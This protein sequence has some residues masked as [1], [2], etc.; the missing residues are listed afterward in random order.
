MDFQYLGMYNALVRRRNGISAIAGGL[1]AA[2]GL[3]F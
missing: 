2:G 1:N 3:V